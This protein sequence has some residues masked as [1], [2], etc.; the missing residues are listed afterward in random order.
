MDIER[1]DLAY[2]RRHDERNCGPKSERSLFGHL[3]RERLYAVC[4]AVNSLPKGSRIIDLGCAQGDFA[5]RLAASGYTVTAVDINPAFLDYART[6][7][8]EGR[9]RWLEADIFSLSI[10]ECFDCVI[11]AEVLEHTGAPEDLLSA[12]GQMLVPGGLLVATT[13]NAERLRE[14]MP[15]FARW[16]AAHPDRASIVFGPAGEHHQYLFTR[17][18]LADLLLS[19]FTDISFA[20]TGSLLVNRQTQWLLR[21]PLGRTLLRMVQRT[22]LTLPV[23]ER[24]ANDWLITARLR[25]GASS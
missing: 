1:H 12:V 14:N 8:V 23:R 6:K 24:L 3:Y 18:E 7:D 9:V 15:S 21:S 11:L 25:A 10:G 5:R 17:R 2:V 16:A 20:P 19:R 4:Q 13:P 22:L